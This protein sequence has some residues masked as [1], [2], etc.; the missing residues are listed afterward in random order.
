MG[1]FSS[2]PFAPRKNSRSHA[3]VWVRLCGRSAAIKL[4]QERLFEEPS[5]RPHFIVAF[6][7][8]KGCIG[9]T[10]IDKSILSRSERRLWPSGCRPF[11]GHRII[12]GAALT[13]RYRRYL[14][15]KVC[16]NPA[17]SAVNPSSD[18]SATQVKAWPSPVHLAVGIF[19]N[20]VVSGFRDQSAPTSHFRRRQP[21]SQG[22][23]V[24]YQRNGA[25]EVDPMSSWLAKGPGS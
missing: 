5:H 1:G 2:S 23:E 9:P 7:S 21:E 8:A 10:W 16:L 20:L 15:F 18:S 25:L 6:R 4:D 13:L 14:P 3:H 19:R 17:R 11:A 24:A 22:R 12:Q